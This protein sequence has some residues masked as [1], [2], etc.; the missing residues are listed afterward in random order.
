VDDKQNFSGAW[1]TYRPVKGQAIDLYYLDL[2]NA[3][4][5]VMGSFV[6]KARQ[7]GS[8]NTDTIGARYAGNQ[9]NLLFDFEGA[10]QFGSW[11]NQTI[12]AGAYTSD[13]GW[14]FAK[15]PGTPQFWIG[16]DFASGDHNPGT[17]DIH[18][19]FNQLFPF[20][21]YYFGFLDLVGRMNIEDLN[22]QAVVWPMKWITCCAQYH[23]FR[24]DS[25]RDALYGPASQVFRVDPTGRA[26]RDVGNELDLWVNFH[27]AQNQDLWVGYSHL[28]EGSFL[29][30]T[31]PGPDPELFYVQ[32]SF[33][34]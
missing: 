24:L 28:Y 5:N 30:K 6:G 33:R 22:F 21:H 3:N 17:S 10:Y 26:G 25:G 2:D 34:W 20:G 8:F 16:Y 11:S 14:N 19:T 12:S 23:L 32:Y 31:G 29:K 18:A 7:A 9:D 1:F 13:V 27:L 4:H 15:L